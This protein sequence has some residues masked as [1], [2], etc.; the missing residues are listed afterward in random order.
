VEWCDR[1][2]D[3]WPDRA[4]VLTLELGVGERRRITATGHGRGAELASAL[5]RALVAV[6]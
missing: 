5:A 3:L 4:L 1:F 6:S 2:A